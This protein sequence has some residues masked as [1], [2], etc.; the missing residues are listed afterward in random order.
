MYVYTYI[1]AYIHACTYTHTHTYIYISHIFM[2]THTYIHIHIHIYRWYGVFNLAKGFAIG[3]ALGT[4]TTPVHNSGFLFGIYAVDFVIQVILRPQIDVVAGMSEL[5]TAAVQVFTYLHTHIH[6]YIHVGAVHSS[7]AGVY[8]YV[9]M[10]FM[11][12]FI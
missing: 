7:P 4:L 5:Y 10:L 6:T 12:I 1:H 8:M 3:I 2:H 11:C 9:S